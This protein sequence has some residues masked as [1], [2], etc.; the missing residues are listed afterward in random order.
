MIR[1]AESCR[2]VLIEHHFLDIANRLLFE[3]RLSVVVNAILLLGRHF[4][5]LNDRLDISVP[6]LTKLAGCPHDSAARA[7]LWLISNMVACDAAYIAEFLSAGLL[8]AIAACV[9]DQS[10][11]CKFEA[12]CVIAEVVRAA[13]PG[14]TAMLVRAHAVAALCQMLQIAERRF[15]LVCAD[16]LVALLRAEAARAEFIAADGIQA[17]EELAGARDCELAAHAR[18]LM[19]AITKLIAE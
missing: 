10:I 19:D 18:A 2:A 8:D 9:A 4:M 11:R 12:A 14:Q 6:R 7:S 15:V 1:D 17:L 3:K 13:A 16:P 5:F